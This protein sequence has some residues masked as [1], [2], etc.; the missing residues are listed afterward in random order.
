MLSRE[1]IERYAAEGREAFE[2]GMA[3]SH[4]PYPQ[5][6]SALLTWIRGYQ[7]AAF[8]ARFARS[9]RADFT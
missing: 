9:E 5:N 4:C 2:R 1:E 8:G 6:S 7:N 3:V